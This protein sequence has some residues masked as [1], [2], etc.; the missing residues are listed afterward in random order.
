M[1]LVILALV[2]VLAACT[3]AN[4]E[5][6]VAPTVEEV[7]TAESAVE[8]GMPADSEVIQQAIAD[9]AGQL[10][11]DESEITVIQAEPVTWSDGSLGCPQPDM[12]YTQALVDGAFIQLE[13]D[14]EVYNYHSGG[15]QTPLLCEG[16][17]VAPGE[18]PDGI[19]ESGATAPSASP[20]ETNLMIPVTSRIVQSAVVDLAN[21]LG[22]LSD[23]VII[24]RAD[25]VV[26]ADGSLG[27]PQPDMMY[28]QVQ[29][30]G[31]FIQ[32]QVGDTIYNYHSGGSQD[33]FLCEGEAAITPG[34]LPPGATGGGQ[35]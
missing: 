26:W 15:D 12:M 17:S 2:A 14:G 6:P 4:S 25:P 3:P 22:V 11:I 23:E 9:L 32:L 27:C 35:S 7:P 20:E 30:E 31:A 13:V 29:V 28:T 24:L 34:E 5:T 1:S 10:G 8:L 18:L 16:E 33:P 21:Q 19:V